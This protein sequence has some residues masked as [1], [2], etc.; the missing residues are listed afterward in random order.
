MHTQDKEENIIN[1]GNSAD[2]DIGYSAIEKNAYKELFQLVRNELFS[3]PV[4]TTMNELTSKLVDIMTDEG[5]TEIKPATKKHIRHKLETEFGESPHIIHD[6]K[7]KLVVYPDTLTR[8]K[9]VLDVLTL[10]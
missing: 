7:G 10:A 2:T 1:E 3:Y 6:S 5:C 9:L 8:D 4:V